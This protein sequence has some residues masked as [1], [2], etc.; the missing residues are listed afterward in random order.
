M[1]SKKWR[2]TGQPDVY[3]DKDDEFT[4]MIVTVYNSDTVVSPVK[5]PCSLRDKR[6]DSQAEEMEGEMSSDG[7]FLSSSDEYQPESEEEYL[8]S[9]SDFWEESEDSE[10]EEIKV[11]MNIGQ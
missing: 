2:R 7:D 1:S 6:V 9:E 3:L 8:D 10:P 5:S 4:P 11:E